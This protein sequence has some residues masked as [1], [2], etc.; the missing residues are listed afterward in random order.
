M[1][2]WTK[3]ALAAFVV[4]VSFA[5]KEFFGLPE[6]GFWRW[7][8]YIF[9]AIVVFSYNAYELKPDLRFLKVR[10]PVLKES[11]DAFFKEASDKLKEGQR[12][13]FRANIMVKKGWWFWQKLEIAHAYEMKSTDADYGICWPRQHGLCWQVFDKG[14]GQW[15]SKEEEESSK[16]GM[17]LQEQAKTDHVFAV[18]SLPVRSSHRNM[19]N[20]VDAVLNIDAITP[21]A[22]KDLQEI[23]TDWEQNQAIV[24]VDLVDLLRLYF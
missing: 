21:E 23:K 14:Q 20:R 1:N 12:L 22:A 11:F 7:L 13:P 10:E 24:V 19:H 16:Y 9:V 6:Q 18:L 2:H 8:L 3:S 17:T 5:A 15:F 4:L